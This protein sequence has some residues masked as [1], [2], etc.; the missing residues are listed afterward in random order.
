[1]R[2]YES[3]WTWE[4]LVEADKRARQCFLDALFRVGVDP[5]DGAAILQALEDFLEV[6]LRRQPPGEFAY[7]T[8]LVRE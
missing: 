7:R 1:M 2:G 4:E 3:R 6:R 8:E 5:A